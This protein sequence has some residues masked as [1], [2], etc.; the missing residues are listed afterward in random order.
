[1]LTNMRSND[2]FIGLPHD[3]FSFTMLQEILARTLGVELGNYSHAVGSL[4]LYTKHRKGA[5]QYLAE[6]WQPTAEMPPMPASDPWNSI[7]KLVEAE[8]S[9]RCNRENGVD[10]LRLA[11]YWK[12]F[13]RL[14]QIFK[15]SKSSGRPDIAQLKTSMS[16]RI[17]DSYID[18]IAKRNA[19][20][21]RDSVV[22]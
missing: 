22:E 13:V 15:Q 19:R 21:R 20:R 12:D 4:H 5:R 2:A 8:R 3:I 11:P 6:G 1:M 9:I 18:A 17:Y 16:T 14:L 7:N 10:K